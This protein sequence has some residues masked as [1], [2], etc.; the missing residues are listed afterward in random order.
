MYFWKR[1]KIIFGTIL[2][3]TFNTMKEITVNDKT[4]NKTYELNLNR[5]TL[6]YNK[7][8]LSD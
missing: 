2:S 6:E 4:H 3:L 1:S 5:E 8:S 7:T